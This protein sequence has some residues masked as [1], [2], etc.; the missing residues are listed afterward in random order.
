MYKRQEYTLPRDWEISFQS[1]KI[2][3]AWPFFKSNS[4]THKEVWE[5]PSPVS[6]THLD[7]YKRQGY[8]LHDHRRNTDIWQELKIM[9]ILDRIAQFWLNWW[10]YLY[11]MDDCC[12]P[13]Q[14]WNY[15]PR[16]QRG[17][18]CLRKHWNDQ[19]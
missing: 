12:I 7:V 5:E 11:R 17:V 18:G 6:Y 16:G 3:L 10:E 8:T 19:L 9:S 13:K 1:L 14:L 4:Q 15:N 2:Q